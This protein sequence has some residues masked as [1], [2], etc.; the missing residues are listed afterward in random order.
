MYT[1]ILRSRLPFL[2]LVV[3]ALN[4]GLGQSPTTAVTVVSAAD[5]RSYVSPQSLAVLLGSNIADSTGSGLADTTG[6]LSTELAGTTVQVCGE[7]AGLAFVSPSR[8]DIVIP[9][10]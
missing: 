10:D 2:A 5:H 8:I 7:A 1:L 6:Q 3:A 9:A 4:I